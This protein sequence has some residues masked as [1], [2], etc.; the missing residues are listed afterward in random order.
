MHDLTAKKDATHMPIGLN[1]NFEALHKRFPTSAYLRA[2]RRATCRSSRSNMATP[3]PAPMSASRITGRRSTP[4]RSCRAMAASPRVPPID[5]ELFGTRYAAPIGI[6]PMGGPSLVWPGAD[7]L[8]AKAAQRA[9]IPYTLGVAGGAT[10]EDVAKVAPD[11]F[12]LQLYRFYQNDHAIGFDLIER[13]HRGRR[14][15]A[16]ADHRRAGAHHALARNLRRARRANSIP[17]S[18]M[19]YEMIDAAEM[20]AG[21]AAPRLSALCHHSPICRRAR[22]HQR[23]HPLRA[24]AIWAACFPGRRSRATATAGRARCWSR[25]SCIRPTPRRPCRSASRASGCRTM[26]AA[27]SRR[28]CRSIDVLPAIVSAVGQEGDRRARQRHPLGPGRDAGAGARRQRGLCRQDLPLG[29]R[30]AGRCR[31]RRI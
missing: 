13:A 25:A 24:Q 14:Q 26:A 6:A 21:A 8:M 17:T 23:S 19:L 11:V 10:I 15:G 7:L 18:R 16:G 27:R 22:Q 5:V 1:P 2:P 4:S 29:G 28:W 20:A 3:A 31:A 12:W 30:R 9:R